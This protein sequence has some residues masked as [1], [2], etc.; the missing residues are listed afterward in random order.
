[1]AYKYKKKNDPTKQPLPYTLDERDGVKVRVYESG[2]VLNDETGKI[3]KPPEHTLITSENYTL[4]H[5]AR[6]QKAA[7][8]L[9]SRI[10]QTH[11]NNMPSQVGSSAAAFAESGAMLYEEIV[12]NSEAYPRDRKEMWETLGKHARVLSPDFNQDAQSSQAQTLTAA[13][14]AGTAQILERLWADVR[15]AQAEADVIPMRI[16][17]EV[18][19]DAQE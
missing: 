14:Q 2:A 17:N 11:N 18:D 4:L 8:L 19:G 5:L 12:L 1:M 3:V 7:A 9:R 13:L 10:K 6:Q 15:R 16:E